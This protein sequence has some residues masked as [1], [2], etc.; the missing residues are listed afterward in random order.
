VGLAGGVHPADDLGDCEAGTTAAGW[1]M[2][3]MQRF[4]KWKNEFEEDVR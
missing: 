2:S 3:V 4:G 1:G